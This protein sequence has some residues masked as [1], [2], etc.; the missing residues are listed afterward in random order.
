LE[1]L[2]GEEGATKETLDNTF[3]EAALQMIYAQHPVSCVA[4]R[5]QPGRMMI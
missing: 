1:F 4:P 2:S 5:R 3:D